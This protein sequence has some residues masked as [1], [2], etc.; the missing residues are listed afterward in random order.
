MMETEVR[1]DP[2]HPDKLQKREVAYLWPVLHA[3]KRWCVVWGEG[4]A[5]GMPWPSDRVEFWCHERECDQ[6]RP[7]KVTSE[8]RQTV[9][10]IEQ[11]SR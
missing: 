9:V 1:I 3:G 2:V 10:Y 6:A 11:V 8:P 7:H 5:K 4:M